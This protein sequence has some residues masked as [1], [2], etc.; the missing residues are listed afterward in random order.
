[1]YRQE[2]D[3]AIPMYQKS[4]QYLT[5]MIS[6]VRADTLFRLALT[7]DE[8]GQ[9][10]D[11]IAYYHKSF[12]VSQELQDNETCASTLYNLAGLYFENSQLAEAKAT[13][14]QCLIYDKRNGVEKDMMRSYL[15]L[16]K[17]SEA[18]SDW[19][20]AKV[21]ASEAYALA[22]PGSANQVSLAMRLGQLF[23][24][25][26]AWKDALKLYRDALVAPSG[27]LSEEHRERL[28]R[29]IKLLEEKLG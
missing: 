17:I 15:Q 4:L 23:E 6:P 8:S 12:E 16:A 25:A 29:K 2:F 13:M 3:K 10:E 14:E 21:Y 9:A 26:E 28:V 1:V 5:T 27:V 11:A 20:S 7:L 24:R 19:T 18:Q 22:E